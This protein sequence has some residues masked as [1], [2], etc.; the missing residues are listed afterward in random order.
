MTLAT[1]ATNPETLWAENT[2]LGESSAKYGPATVACAADFYNRYPGEK[3]TLFIR[4]DVREEMSDLTLT[5]QIPGG[6]ELDDYGNGYQQNDQVVYVNGNR[7]MKQLIWQLKGELPV[8]THREYQ[9]IT[10]VGPTYR[11]IELMNTVLLK[12][13]SGLVIG[14]DAVSINVL[15]KGQY[16]RYLP[17]LYEQDDLTNRFLMLF[18]SFWAPIE[19]QINGVHNYFDPRITPDSILP[20]LASWLDLSLDEFWTEAQLRQ[21]IRWAIALHRSRGTKWGLLKYLEIY[22]GQQ[23]QII[24]HRAKNFVLGPDTRIGPGIALGHHNTPHTFSVRLQLPALDI[25]DEH[26]RN[27][28]EKIQRRTIESIIEMQKPAHTVYTL[29]LETVS[30]EELERQAAISDSQPDQAEPVDQIAGQ[31]ETWFK[32]D[33]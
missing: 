11:D 27:R 12:S 18:E 5:I 28:Q 20:W 16:L 31:A 25:E 21:L 19:S 3:V 13:E 17:A 30:L 15:A 32:L 1:S 9:L 23:A 10:T 24:E 14:Q 2:E 29:H 4:V 6:L 26:E 7:S 33:S 8:G 22:T